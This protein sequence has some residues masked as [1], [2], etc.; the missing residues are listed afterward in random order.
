MAKQNEIPT[1]VFVPPFPT[2]KGIERDQWSRAV[3]GFCNGSQSVKNN[4]GI[5]SVRTGNIIHFEGEVTIS[6]TFCNLEVLPVVPRQN[7]Y[8]NA[9]DSLGNIK[10]IRI[11]EGLKTLNMCSLDEG[12]YFVTGSYIANIKERI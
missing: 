5:L 6:G 11:Y 4:N 10:G 7:G 3:A 8:V 1:T 2:E 12:T 9:Y